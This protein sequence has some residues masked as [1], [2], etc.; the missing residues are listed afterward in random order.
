[1][2]LLGVQNAHAVALLRAT[3]A[4]GLQQPAANLIAR[5]CKAVHAE[6]TTGQLLPSFCVTWPTTNMHDL[7]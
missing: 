7:P 6:H 3:A 5:L 1:M 4:S 2:L